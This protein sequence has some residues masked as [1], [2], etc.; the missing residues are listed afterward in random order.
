MMRSYA[1]S[2][3]C[4]EGIVV[5]LSSSC[6]CIES[7]KSSAVRSDECSRVVL[8]LAEL[9]PFFIGIEILNVGVRGGELEK[10]NFNAV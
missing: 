7:D 3:I 4:S 2:G 8:G 5:L 1:C 6:S 9:A 10:K